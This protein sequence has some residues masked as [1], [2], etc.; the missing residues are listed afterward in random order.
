MDAPNP[1]VTPTHINSFSPWMSGWKARLIAAIGNPASMDWIGASTAIAI[2]FYVPWPYPVKR[3]FWVNGATIAGN[4]DI[5]IFTS[6]AGKRWTAG[7]TP[8]A[9]ASAPQYVTVTPGLVLEPGWHVLQYVNDGTTGRAFGSTAVTAN[10]GR[11]IGVYQQATAFPL[12]ATPAWAQWA[13]I[14][15]PLIGIT[16]TASGF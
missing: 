2:P 10:L 3:A 9:G 4:S 11:F 12:P 5:G 13:S 16:R 8:N 7:S 6:R 15:Y 14:G 1:I